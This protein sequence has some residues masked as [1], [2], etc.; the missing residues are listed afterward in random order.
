MGGQRRIALIALAGAVIGH[1]LLWKSL[2]SPRPLI[3][4][5]TLAPLE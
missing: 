2:K 5:S 1:A 4:T 3:V